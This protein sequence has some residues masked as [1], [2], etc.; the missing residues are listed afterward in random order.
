VGRIE[1]RDGEERER[2]GAD[3]VGAPFL[4]PPPPTFPPSLPPLPFLLFLC[5]RRVYIDYISIYSLLSRARQSNETQPKT[6]NHRELREWPRQNRE[7]ERE[8]EWDFL[9]SLGVCGRACMWVAAA[10]AVAA[11]EMKM[12]M[13]ARSASTRK[14]QACGLRFVAIACDL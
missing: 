10:A 5:R 8:R 4:S 3:G 9:E 7:G 1:R 13:R 12:R 11:A 2:Q 6:K 14:G